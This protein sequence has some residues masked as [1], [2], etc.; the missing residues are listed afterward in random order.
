MFFT[1]VPRQKPGCKF[2]GDKGWVYVDRSGIWAEPASLLKVKIKPEEEQLTDSK[3]H[4]DDFLQCIRSRKDPVS[5]VDASHKATCL[6]L[7]ADISA[8]LQQ[9]LRWD[10]QQERF[11]ENDEANKMLRRPMHN[12][13][14]L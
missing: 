1:D 4:G 8:R 13:W 3:H 14:K 11:E 7:I 2:I 12:G 6:G 9:K 10:P 5:S